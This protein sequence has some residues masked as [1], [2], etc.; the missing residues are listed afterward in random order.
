[1]FIYQPIQVRRLMKAR[2]RCLKK[3]L[4]ARKRM[5]E[6]MSGIPVVIFGPEEPGQGN[7]PGPTLQ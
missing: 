7:T 2:T 5:N 4:D 6:M 3:M 1:M